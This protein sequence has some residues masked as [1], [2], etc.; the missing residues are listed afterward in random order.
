MT[1]KL[2]WGLI[3]CG[4]VVRKRVAAAIADDPHSELVAACRRNAEELRA[5]CDSWSIDKA[6][7]EAAELVQ[8]EEVDAVYIAT[9]V[10]EHLP[11]TLLAAAA[12]KHVLVEK[13]M[14]VDVA[15]C[16]AMIEACQTAGVRLGVAYY[17]R[18]YPLVERIEQLLQSGAIGTP[19]G[20]SAVTATPLDLADGEPP[21]WRMV[22][23]SSGGG[24]LMDVGSHRINVFLHLLGEIVEVKAICQNVAASYEAEDSAVLLFRFAGGP[25]GTLQCHFG[26]RDP[27]QFAIIGTRGRLSAEPLNGD[28]LAIEIDGQKQTESHPPADNFCAP[29]IADFVAAVREGREPK[30]AGCEGRATNRV[31]AQAYRSAG[32]AA[33]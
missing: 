30:V 20:V 19:L 14:A 29:L 4:D 11:Q 10:A 27:D 16:D 25:L 24:A 2:R 3:G 28:R 12:G 21:V 32:E 33:S 17:R 23:R 31:M 13:P 15:E 26:A 22:Q 18:F 5:F 9:P 1:Q 7:T 6:Y 8:D